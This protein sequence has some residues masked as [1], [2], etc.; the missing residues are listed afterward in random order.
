MDDRE[1]EK[2][3]K[4]RFPKPAGPNR[5]AYTA[6]H[7][8]PR[9][10]HSGCGPH[11]TITEIHLCCFR[12]QETPVDTQV[13]MEVRPRSSTVLVRNNAMGQELQERTAKVSRPKI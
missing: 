8:T 10:G 6:M 11:K 4:N 2:V 3:A 5:F 9:E 1:N 12:T 7:D 13:N